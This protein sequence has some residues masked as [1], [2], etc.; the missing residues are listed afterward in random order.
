MCGMYCLGVM[1]LDKNKFWSTEKP[2]IYLSKQLYSNYWLGYEKYV[3]K[4]V[5]R[6]RTYLQI[7]LVLFREGGGMAGV[8]ST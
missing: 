2:F 3:E 5:V 6:V 7:S 1:W 4:V 8:T